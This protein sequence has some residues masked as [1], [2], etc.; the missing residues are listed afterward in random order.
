MVGGCKKSSSTG[1]DTDIPTYPVTA[2]VLDPQGYPLGGATLTLLNPPFEDPKFTSLTDSTG[3][4]TIQSPAGQQT[5]LAKFGTVFEGTLNVTVAASSTPTI[6][7]TPIQVHQ[8]TSLGKVLVV[9]ASAEQLEDVLHAIGYTTFDSISVEALRDSAD[10]DSTKLLQYLKQYKLI[11]SDC[12]GGDEYQYPLLARTYGRYVTDGGKIYGGHYNYYILQYIWPPYFK[13]RDYQG[14]VSTDTL[15]I[16]DNNLQKAVGTYL[17]WTKS[18]DSRHLSDYQKFSDL[19]P[20]PISHTYGVIKGT[21]PE[22]GVIVECYPN[23][24]P[25]GGK[26]LWTDY[27]NQDILNNTKLLKIVTYFLNGM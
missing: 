14:D 21:S 1:P 22:V 19:P 6:V 13:Q 9:L 4:A 26:Y 2:K 20:A 24:N 16:V 10:T 7:T 3:K 18:E 25:N 5:L 12:N 23:P 27:H 8:N 11:F 15:K 17:D